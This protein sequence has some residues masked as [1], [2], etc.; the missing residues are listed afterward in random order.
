MF[1]TLKNKAAA[2]Y[3]GPAKIELLK[4]AVLLLI[5]TWGM[6]WGGGGGG[7]GRGLSYQSELY[8]SYTL[9]LAKFLTQYFFSHC[10]F[11]I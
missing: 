1:P 3:Q 11:Y 4:E 6:E 9:V 8:T 2:G 10:I 7:G 5:V